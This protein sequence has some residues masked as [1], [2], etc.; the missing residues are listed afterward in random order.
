MPGAHAYP[1]DRKPFLAHGARRP[2]RA[3]PSQLQTF[4]RGEMDRSRNTGFAD[5][6]GAAA[7]AKKAQLER[8]ARARS[9]AGGPGAVD[10]R[11]AREAVSLAREARA[12]ERKAAKL[13]MEAR[14]SAE[15]AAA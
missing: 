3:F 2:C 12:A 13:A 1:R 9:G 5:R 7:D 8:A 4:T 14:Q 10:R 11:A 15:L 6:L